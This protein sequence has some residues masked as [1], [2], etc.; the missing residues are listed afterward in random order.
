MK[1]TS[2]YKIGLLSE[3]IDIQKILNHYK[4]TFAFLLIG[5][6]IIIIFFL[7]WKI[8]ELNSTNLE[9]ILNEARILAERDTLYTN[10]VISHGSVYIKSNNS[11]KNNKNNFNFVPPALMHKQLQQQLKDKNKLIIKL[12]SLNSINPEYKADDWESK[13]FEHFK[14]GKNEFYSFDTI[15]N[16]KYFRYIIPLKIKKECLSCHANQKIGE[17]KGAYSIALLS[18]NYDR[19]YNH[20]LKNDIILHLLIWFIGSFA[21]TF[22]FRKLYSYLKEI[23]LSQEQFY[24]LLNNSPMSTFIKDGEGN[25][26]YMNKIAE[27]YLPEKFRNGKWKGLKDSDIWEPEIVQKLR[28]HDTEVLIS[29]QSKV[30][31]ETIMSEGKKH[32]WLTHKFPLKDTSSGKVYIIGMEIDI[33]ERKEKEDEIKKYSRQLEELNKNKDKFI[34]VLAHDLRGPFT[35]ILGYTDLL[36]TSAEYLTYQEIKEFAHSLDVIVKNQFQLLENVLDWSRLEGNRLKIEPRELNLFDEVKKILNL[37]Q[38][39]YNDKE[40]QIIEKVDPAYEIITDQHSLNT[41]LRNLIS[42]AIKFTPHKGTIQIIASK[43]NN[44]YKIKIIDSGVGIPKENLP[45]IFGGESGFT[46]RGTNNEKGTGLGLTI[47]KELIEKLGGK[48]WVESEVGKGSTFT[49]F[50]PNLKIEN[51]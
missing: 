42:N 26:I 44:G 13:S 35:P 37:Y 33:T 1:E 48:I 23:K 14:K 22:V 29:M 36:A 9:L 10:W 27:Q 11:N 18:S 31:E 6:T 15:N 4:L 28:E 17:I 43:E 7:S 32:V 21:F 24:E 38:P 3:K 50:L 41:I 34:S 46:T 47:C 40:I 30:F 16:K 8:S 39:I 51:Q 45:K 2:K 49:I 19:Y 5:W 20:Q 25:L 12:T